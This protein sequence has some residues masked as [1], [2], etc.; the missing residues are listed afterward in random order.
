MSIID[1]LLKGAGNMKNIAK[2][3]YMGAFSKNKEIAGLLESEFAGV[4]KTAKDKGPMSFQQ[5]EDLLMD[6]IGKK[7]AVDIEGLGTKNAGDYLKKVRGMEDDFQGFSQ[8]LKEI[9]TT[10]E[11]LVNLGGS[12]LKGAAGW[13]AAGG[14]NEWAHGGSAWEGFKSGAVGGL[15]KG[16]VWKGAKMMPYG[17]KKYTM[18]QNQG[19]GPNAFDAIGRYREIGEQAARWGRV[20]ANNPRISKQLKAVYRNQREAASAVA[21]VTQNTR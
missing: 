11:G 16:A 9:F 13:G 21:N 14:L 12:A 8:N 20:S 18:L 10:E 7:S 6:F 19:A 17:A 3:E 1:Y 2:R 5:Q 4:M 15:A